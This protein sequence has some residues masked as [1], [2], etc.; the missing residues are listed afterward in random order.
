M[1]NDK[2]ILLTLAIIICLNLY[3]EAEFARKLDFR[4]YPEKFHPCIDNDKIIFTDFSC[5]NLPKSDGILRLTFHRNR[6]TILIL[7][8]GITIGLD[9]HFSAYKCIYFLTHHF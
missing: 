2:I 6:G 7:N 5:Y 1:D 3:F 9:K 8:S 4:N